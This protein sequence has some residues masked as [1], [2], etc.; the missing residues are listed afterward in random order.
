M[1]I[2]LSLLFFAEKTSQKL[3][4]ALPIFRFFFPRRK[5]SISRSAERD[6]RFAAGSRK[7]FEKVLSK[8]LISFALRGGAGLR[9]VSGEERIF[10]DIKTA[11]VSALTCR[12][13]RHDHAGR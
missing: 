6:R 2:L 5:E 11:R 10:Y 13:L 12:E 3:V 7:T 8:L 4:T 1:L 9:R